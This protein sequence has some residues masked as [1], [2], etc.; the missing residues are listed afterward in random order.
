LAMGDSHDNLLS[1]VTPGTRADSIIFA[2]DST[3]SRRES[4]GRTGQFVTSTSASL[5]IG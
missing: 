5:A 3:H 4:D 1:S 2:L